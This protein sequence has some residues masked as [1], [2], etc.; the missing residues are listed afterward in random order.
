MMQLNSLTL[1]ID[2]LTCCHVTQHVGYRTSINFVT[3]L[4]RYFNPVYDLF[5][6]VTKPR[7][8]SRLAAE[9]GH[10]N[11]WWVNRDTAWMKTAHSFAFLKLI[12]V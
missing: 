8:Y 2:L 11:I 6:N 7:I 1:A 10:Y 9:R 3:R 4:K 12:K 5:L